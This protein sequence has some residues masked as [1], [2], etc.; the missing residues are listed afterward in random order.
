MPR[1]MEFTS[2]YQSKAKKFILGILSEE[3]QLGH[4][5]RPDL[6][7]ISNFYQTKKSN[8]WIA[9]SGRKII[10]TIALLDYGRNGYLK[11][12]YVDK[13]YRGFGIAKDLL[14]TVLKYSKSEG[15]KKIYLG[16]FKEMKSA[17]KFYLKNNFKKI[18]SLPKEMPNLGD[19]IF[20]RLTL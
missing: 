1:I 16:T 9:V 12:M 20:Y 10:G 19:G 17:K 7:A 18:K 4:I 8:F 2:N 14:S 13:K 11:R 5:K 6:D 15:F 3:F